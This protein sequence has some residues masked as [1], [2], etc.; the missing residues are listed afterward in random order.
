[1]ILLGLFLLG[2]VASLAGLLIASNLSAT[3]TS[4]LRLLGHTL[5]AVTAVDI[6]T[7][8]MCM[9]L[10]MCLGVWITATGVIE[11]RRRIRDETPADEF[12]PGSWRTS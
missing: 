10:L 2:G 6:F 12:L 1:M 5:P 4:S 7:A 3:T 11:R 9:A 8:G